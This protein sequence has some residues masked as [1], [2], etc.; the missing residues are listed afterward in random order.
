M[1]LLKL[2]ARL[3]SRYSICNKLLTSSLAT[4]DLLYIDIKLSR[5]HAI[6]SARSIESV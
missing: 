3:W 2:I 5:L 4:V 1:I 6:M